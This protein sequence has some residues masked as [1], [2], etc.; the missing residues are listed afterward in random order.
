MCARRPWW[1]SA[2]SPIRG[3]KVVNSRPSSARR[4]QRVLPERVSTRSTAATV[5]SASMPGT[6]PA[7]RRCSL[8]PRVIDGQFIGV[9]V[10]GTKV[11]VAT[12]ERGELA[13][14][15]VCPTD[16]SNADALLDQ[17]VE[18]IGEV[19]TNEARA[20]GIGVPSVV[21]FA[22]GRIRYSVNIPLADLPLRKLLSD[23]L[24]LPVYLENDANCAGLAEAYDGERLIA[25]DLVM[26]TLGTGVGG[27]FV[28]NGRVYRGLTGA[29]PELGHIII[30]LDLEHAVPDAADRFPQRGALEALASG[31]A[32]DRLAE[33]VAREQPESGLGR[34]LAERGE[35]TGVDAVELAKAGDAAATSTVT[36][37]GRRLGIGIANAINLF[38]PQE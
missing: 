29:A 17:L 9:D 37:V 26:F 11:A 3:R 7:G 19:R 28:F 31:R 1:R 22:T 24:G 27:G 38:D 4:T 6:T 16:T 25:T 15:T 23:R 8:R 13:E 20:V 35:V 32:L 14:P 30:G 33:R 10:G 2:S 34:R 21:E 18:M 36:L 12:L 5:T